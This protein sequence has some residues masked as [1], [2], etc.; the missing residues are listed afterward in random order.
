MKMML[1]KKIDDLQEKVKELTGN[2]PD[3]LYVALDQLKLCRLV[4][5]N[6]FKKLSITRPK[7]LDGVDHSQTGSLQMITEKLAYVLE[8]ELNEEFIKQPNWG[9]KIKKLTKIST[10][11]IERLFE[12]V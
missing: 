11:F 12:T 1:R 5:L 7:D 2:S 3:F 6:M 4:L 9:L 10:E 8:K